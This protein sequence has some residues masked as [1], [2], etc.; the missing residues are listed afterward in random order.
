MEYNDPIN[1]TDI[2]FIRLLT[3]KFKYS[4]NTRILVNLIKSFLLLQ[5]LRSDLTHVLFSIFP[6]DLSFEFFNFEL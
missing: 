3:Q 5:K 4:V 2:L 1:L 6:S